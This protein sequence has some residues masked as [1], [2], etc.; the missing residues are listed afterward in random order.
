MPG[1]PHTNPNCDFYTICVHKQE[2][3]ATFLWLRFHSQSQI[4]ENRWISAHPRA[5]LIPRLNTNLSTPMSCPQRPETWLQTWL[6]IHTYV[7][8]QS[9]P[10][11]RRTIGDQGSSMSHPNLTSKNHGHSDHPC[12]T[13]HIQNSRVECKLLIFTHTQ[14]I[15]YLLSDQGPF[16][17]RIISSRYKIP[18]PRG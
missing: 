1:I 10:P 17:L 3:I 15:T 14:R 18:V 16:L 7:T 9:L 11:F 8:F 5:R 2:D 13:T 4:A 6:D 12:L